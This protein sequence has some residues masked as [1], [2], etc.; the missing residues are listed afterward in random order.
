MLTQELSHGLNYWEGGSKERIQQMFPTPTK[1]EEDGAKSFMESYH[2]YKREYVKHL[3]FNHEE[4]NLSKCIIDKSCTFVSSFNP[5]EEMGIL[6]NPS[7]FAS[8]LCA[9]TCTTGGSVHLLR[10]SNL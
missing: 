7:S 3:G 2:K 9:G 6:D 8:S 10:H 5:K 1:E 4:E